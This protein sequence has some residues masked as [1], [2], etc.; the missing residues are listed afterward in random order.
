VSPFGFQFEPP[1]VGCYFGHVEIRRA[2]A[3][4]NARAAGET[5]SVTSN[6][7]NRPAVKVQ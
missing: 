6:P 5:E 7:D 4:P 2:R 1:D 3:R